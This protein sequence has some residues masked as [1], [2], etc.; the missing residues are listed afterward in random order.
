M[1]KVVRIYRHG[2]PEELRF[3]DL[4]IGEPGV[5]EVRLKIEAIGL[6]RSEAAFRAG[7]YPVTPKFPTLIGYEG[8]GIVEALGAVWRGSG[9]A[10]VSVCCP[11]SASVS[12]VSTASAPLS[13]R[14]AC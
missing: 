9:S 13:R 5:A 12:T 2:G 7:E 6:N 1:T 10:N 11:T 14:A 3:E 4:D 8:V